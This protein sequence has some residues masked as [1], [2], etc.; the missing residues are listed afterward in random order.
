MADESTARALPDAELET[1]AEPAPAPNDSAP[2]GALRLVPRPEYRPTIREL[3]SG[4]RPRERL[5]SYGEAALSTTELLA[6][7][8]RV[9]MAGENVLDVAGRLLSQHGGL[10]GLARLNFDEWKS[11]QYRLPAG[12][13]R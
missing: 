9:G 12:W 3:P 5:R 11:S 4:E 8:L 2:A 10:V 13:W 7:I 1:E 6:I